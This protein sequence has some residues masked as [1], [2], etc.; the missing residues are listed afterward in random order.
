MHAPTRYRQASANGTG[1][2]VPYSGADDDFSAVN[3]IIPHRR[4]VDCSRHS[5][6]PLMREVPRRG[7]GRECAL[8][9]YSLLLIT[10]KESPSQLR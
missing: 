3:G 1:K 10:S 8:I 6:L 4:A 2:P 7:G 5:C 9:H